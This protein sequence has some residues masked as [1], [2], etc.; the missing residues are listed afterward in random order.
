MSMANL[1]KRC[2]VLIKYGFT[3]EQTRRHNKRL[4]TYFESHPGDGWSEVCDITDDQSTAPVPLDP[5][6]PQ[7]TDCGATD[8]DFEFSYEEQDNYPFF[9]G[10]TVAAGKIKVNE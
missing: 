9:S 5:E 7:L 2:A 10:L 3:F 8:Q 4:L 1:V 6:A